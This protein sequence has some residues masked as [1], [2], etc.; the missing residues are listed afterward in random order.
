[1]AVHV[2]NQN[3]PLTTASA[4]AAQAYNDAIT[5][6]LDYRVTA[7]PSVKR[8]LELDPAFCMAHCL[9]GYML[10]MY[11]TASFL[12]AAR[13]AL[14]TAQEHSAGATPREQAHV[15]ALDLWA[16]GDLQ[17]ACAAWQSLLLEHP[18]D[19]L[20]LRLHHFVSFWMG[21]AQPL[22]AMP[23]AVLPAW[24]PGTPNRGNVLG[25]LAFGLEENGHCE[26]AERHGREAVDLNP[27]DLWAVHSVA[28]VLETQHRYQDGLA[29]TNF[30][31]DQ[32]D[33]RNPFRGHLW[34]HRGLFL[35]EA[36]KL[37][38][39][40]ALYDSAIYDTK[41][42]FYLDIQNAAA[43]LARLEFRGVDVGGRW[44]PLAGHA[45]GHF[46]DRALV[47]TDIHCVMSLART[48]RFDDARAFIDT[49]KAYSVNNEFHV[50]EVLRRVGVQV[51]EGVLAFEKGNYA[52]ALSSFS[53]AKPILFE[54]GAS[55]AQREVI[56]EYAMEA[57][58]RA[59]DGRTLQ[60][61]RQQQDFHR[62]LAARP[63]PLT[64]G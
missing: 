29:W 59:G 20:A 56:T 64:Q 34:W 60:Y 52:E 2:D 13:N 58:R 21:R 22:L 11:S 50:A 28:H 36:G 26:L 15:R 41:S 51:C 48:G 35:I 25:M 46:E 33:D 43:L 17:Q 40:L 9:R 7:M 38:E 1:M 39:A 10:V 32:W 54:V 4:E 62:N 44:E 19:I 14:A 55:N 8:A 49:L 57:A 16:H 53:V 30:A 27:N 45:Q 23:A 6:L 24:K 63:S 31:R 42:D 18:L 37:D 5:Q 12:P 3:L 47:F 61:L